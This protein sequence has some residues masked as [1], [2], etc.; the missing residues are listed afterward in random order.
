MAKLLDCDFEVGKF[1]LQLRYCIHF[2]TNTL[3]NVMNPLILPA[4]G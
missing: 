2:L 3:D 4:K 1:E